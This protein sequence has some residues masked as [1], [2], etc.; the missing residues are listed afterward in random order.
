M[1]TFSATYSPE[2]N[3]LRLYASTRLDAELYARVKGAGFI[4]A[5]KQELFVAP[6]WTPAR[7]D[8][9]LELAGEVGDE[10]TSLVDR[11]EQRADR[12][13]GYR[14]NRRADSEAAQRAV[15]AI[16]DNIPL[17]QPILVGHHSER[18]ARRDQ[19][20]IESGMR[21]AVHM[22][23]TAK[24]WEAR[25]AGALLHA[26]YKDRP[27]VRA[28]RIKT[29]EAELRKCEREKAQAQS[30]CQAWTGGPLTI[31]Q[32]RKLAN[33]SSFYVTEANSNGQ[34]WSAWDVLRPDEDRYAACPSM[35]VEEVQTILKERY[36]KLFPR[37]D[38]WIRHYQLR[39]TYECTMLDAQG[40]S[41]LLEKKPR[42]KLAPLLNYRAPGGSITIEN[43]YNRGTTITYLQVEMTREEYARIPNDYRGCRIGP[44]KEHRF[45]MAMRPGASL[46][47]VFITNSAEHPAPKTPD[48]AAAAEA[49][50]AQAQESSDDAPVSAACP[51]TPI[52][53][54]A[55][56]APADQADTARASIDAM[57][58]ALKAGIQIRA[59]RNLFVTSADLAARMVDLADIRAE[60]TVLEPSAGTGAIVHAIG[61]DAARTGA[62][63]VEIDRGLAE[64]LQERFP[65]W[66][67]DNCDFLGCTRDTLGSFDRILMNPPFENGADITHIQHAL[68]M[69]APGGRLV[70]ICAN[71]PRQRA[72]LLPLA[73]ASGGSWADLPAGSFKH[74]GTMVNTALL[75]IH[76]PGAST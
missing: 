23:E 26:N 75:V 38:R 32:A 39:I 7:E 70:A 36:A 17:G 72:R 27:K 15:S 69:L 28:R 43:Q 62:V 61:H 22:W 21:R 31:E 71:G 16:A 1:I 73:E 63:A 58:Q 5:P 66:I 65:R 53:E 12:F 24:Y 48:A 19:K 4:W 47:S 51:S 55:P 46:V 35:T 11:A 50:S 42:P 45:R 8:L 60:H 29:L 34:R 68:G 52:E 6:M 67:V 59:V 25:A 54:P 13:D 20:R 2:D 49:A 57:K 44:D 64:Q 74:A 33:V 41:D 40:A 18:H 56:P 76:G 37:L 14:D 3:K 10:D 30:R 9:C